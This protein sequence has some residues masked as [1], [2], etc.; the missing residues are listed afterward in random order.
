MA[1]RGGS[2]DRESLEN[3]A[4]EIIGEIKDMVGFTGEILS[5]QRRFSFMLISSRK[6]RRE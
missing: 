2:N 3:D 6:P 1:I 5:M 4:K